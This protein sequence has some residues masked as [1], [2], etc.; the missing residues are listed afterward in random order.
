L[1]HVLGGRFERRLTL[2]V[3]G[4]GFGKTSLLVQAREENLLSPRGFD[5]WFG[6]RPSHDAASML[7]RELCALTGAPGAV[8]PWCA[9]G[10]GRRC[11]AA[12]MPTLEDV[13]ARYGSLSEARLSE[14]GRWAGRDGA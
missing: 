4:P 13:L 3:A 5:L 11:D 8:S 2:L 14:P 7:G 10:R 12:G 9:T 1:A 6:C